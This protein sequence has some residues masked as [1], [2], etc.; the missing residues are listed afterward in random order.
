MARRSGSACPEIP[1][2][3]PS[4]RQPARAPPGWFS[5]SWVSP[6]Y[7]CESFGTSAEHFTIGV[8]RPLQGEHA[9][10]GNGKRLERAVFEPGGER[11]ED[12]RAVGHAE[13]E[14]IDPDESVHAAI[15]R[16][17]VEWHRALDGGDEDLP[18][19]LGKARVGLG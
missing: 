6:R 8:V 15:E 10:F 2:R 5:F 18:A 9:A 1:A 19:A 7:E 14:R 11:L 12:R 4:L 13:R 16:E 17:D 3:W